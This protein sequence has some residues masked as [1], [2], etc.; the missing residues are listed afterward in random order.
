MDQLSAKTVVYG[1]HWHNNKCSQ[2]SI[3]RG[4]YN[5]ICSCEILSSLCFQSYTNINFNISIH[6]R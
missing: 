6:M 5:T 3:D 4:A 1:H 2:M